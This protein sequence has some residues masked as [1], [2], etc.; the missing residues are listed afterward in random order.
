MPGMAPGNS[1]QFVQMRSMQEIANQSPSTQK[2]MQFQTM[3]NNFSRSNSTI[4]QRYESPN[5]AKA[6]GSPSPENQ[7]GL[8]DTLKSGIESLS[9]FS[10]DDVKVHYNSP[11]PAQLQA[12]AYAQGTDIHLGRGQEK[13][14]PHE[15]WHVVQQ[16]QG[17]VQATTQL[18]GHVPVNDEVSLER[19]ADFMGAK[20][21]QSMDTGVQSAPLSVA[22]V[23]NSVVQG[24]FIR[25]PSQFFMVF[26]DEYTGEFFDQTEVLVDNKVKVKGRFS[27]QELY[28]IYQPFTQKWEPEIQL[29][30]MGI[31]EPPGQIE[32][33]EVGG[34]GNV[35]HE[36]FE[37]GHG[38]ESEEEEEEAG[39]YVDGAMGNGN[40]VDFGQ[41]DGWEIEEEDG[42][43][44]HAPV[45]MGILDLQEEDLDSSEDEDYDPEFDLDEYVKDLAWDEGREYAIDN[46][47]TG[48]IPEFMISLIFEG[49]KSD[50]P[51][52][53]GKLAAFT[54][55]FENGFQE[56]REDI[57]ESGANDYQ[58][59]EQQMLQQELAEL[60]AEQNLFEFF[61]TDAAGSDQSLEGLHRVSPVIEEGQPIIKVESNPV[62]LDVIIAQKKWENYVIGGA[63]LTSLKGAATKAQ[64][65]LDK[66][67][68]NSAK[69]I[70]GSR[71]KGN[72]N[73]FRSALHA[74]AMILT[75]L[76]GAAHVATLVPQTDLSTSDNFGNNGSPTEG[77]HV[78]AK[79]LSIKS[80]TA[81]SPPHDGRLMAAIRNLAGANSKSYVQMHLLNDLVFGPGEL[82]NLT[83]G[84]KKS[85]SDMEKQVEDPLKRAI[86]SKGLVIDFE[87]IVT[88]KNDPNAA[89]TSDINKDPDNYRM[90]SIKFKAVQKV[91]HGPSNSWVT[92]LVQDP[93]V[94]KVHN[95]TINWK[96]GSL[97]PLVPKP[98]IM[99][100]GTM[101]AALTAIGLK[102]AAATRIVAFIAATS[103]G[104]A[105]VPIGGGDKKG[106]LADL[107]KAFDGKSTKP[108]MAGWK[109]TDVLWT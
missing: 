66:I 92:K 11:R 13:H 27:Q 80:A 70:T 43:H 107:V 23:S 108:N 15:A 90:T 56:A 100:P 109:A 3:A 42:Q 105:A 68:G 98:R 85:N 83:P 102:N 61:S 25:V 103:V 38:W 47:E 52:L 6:K 36:D 46:H 74:V 57:L 88:Y 95:S 31:P 86:L 71:T 33:E 21:M 17:R 60:V 2:A 79:P 12:H 18:K 14:L 58:E 65:K 19:E 10:M 69:G 75:H 37:H 72:M 89:T 26:Q 76:G 5:S 64:D 77:T 62:A 22:G 7:T 81:G 4:L 1:P 55:G 106:Q 94:T 34:L 101:V 44:L 54:E 63:V 97:P 49:L 91:Y 93:D 32:E 87:A 24:A 35:N 67:A 96:Y 48:F 29:V 39:G 41:V 78:K 82:W 16:K 9:G 20:A 99:H 51:E 73:T 40:Q 8:P 59:Y 28:I 53:H 30:E 50:F 84:P 45:G 104:G